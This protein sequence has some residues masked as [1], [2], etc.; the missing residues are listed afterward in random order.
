MYTK[1]TWRWIRQWKP[2]RLTTH[3]GNTEREKIKVQA[4]P[5]GLSLSLV[6]LI[7]RY[8][9]IRMHVHIYIIVT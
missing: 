7:P 8:M 1:Y 9:Y 2:G 4:T 6:H 3:A 5:V